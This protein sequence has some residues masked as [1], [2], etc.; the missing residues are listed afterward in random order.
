MK[1][2]LG[3]T[4]LA[5]VLLAALPASAQ[6]ATAK[7]EPKGGL[8]LAWLLPQDSLKDTHDKGY[9]IHMFFAYQLADKMDLSMTTGWNR[10]LA[11]SEA[12]GAEDFTMWEFTAG[13]RARISLFY[14]GIEGGWFTKIDEFGWVPNAGVRY[15]RFDVG[16]RMKTSGETK[17]HT[18]RAGY[19]F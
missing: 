18:I 5:V 4:A 1:N 9:G 12:E 19:F 16:Y 14:L 13:P 11:D 3:L 7:P 10:L 6:K 15:K 8:A 2:I 17:V